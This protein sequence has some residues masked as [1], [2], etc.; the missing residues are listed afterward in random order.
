MAYVSSGPRTGGTIAIIDTA[1]DAVVG[2][3][4][5][6]TGGTDYVPGVGAGTAEGL[7]TDPFWWFEK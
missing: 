6:G 2:R 5:V 1:K 4:K 3:I 7:A